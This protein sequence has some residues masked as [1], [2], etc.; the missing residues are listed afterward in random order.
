MVAANDAAP[1]QWRI[2]MA[3]LTDT[4][5]VILSFLPAILAI[6]IVSPHLADQGN[7]ENGHAE[8]VPTAS[9]RRFWAYLEL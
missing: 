6:W 2:P 8:M 3:R 7:K 9:D 5:L 4:Q 1:T